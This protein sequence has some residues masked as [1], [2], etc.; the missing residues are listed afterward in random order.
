[1]HLVRE[2]LLLG[3]DDVLLPQGLLELLWADDCLTCLQGC[4]VKHIYDTSALKST[5]QVSVC[6]CI[7]THTYSYRNTYTK[8]TL[9]VVHATI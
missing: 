6:V 5:P 3:H 1:M 2:R 4:N 7:H 9:R 8:F